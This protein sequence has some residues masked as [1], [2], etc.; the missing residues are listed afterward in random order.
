MNLPFANP[1]PYLIDY[2]LTD[3][4]L[5]IVALSGQF[6]LR[7]FP[8][9]EMIAVKRGYELWNEHYEN[10]LDLWNAAVSV[11]LD[12]AILPWLVLT[13]AD[14]DGF[15]RDLSARIGRTRA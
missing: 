1:L 8:F 3:S 4:S 9:K 13:P 2:R 5:Q 11:R 12:R 7:E 14:P 15:V 6:V 10:R